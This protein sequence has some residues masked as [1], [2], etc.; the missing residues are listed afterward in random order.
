MI[1]P[2]LEPIAVPG[3]AP[4]A[5]EAARGRRRR[6]RRQ[7][8]VQARA[9]A[10]PVV[11][12][13]HTM[14]DRMPQVQHP[15]NGIGRRSLAPPFVQAPPFVAPPAPAAAPA[16]A[17]PMHV[18]LAA[19]A[20]PFVRAAPAAPAQ[21]AQPVA[22]PGNVAIAVPLLQALINPII[23]NRRQRKHRR[24]KLHG[25]F[26]WESSRAWR[27]YVTKKK[28]NKNKYHKLPKPESGR[29]FHYEN[30]EE[31][32]KWKETDDI[33]HKYKPRMV[34]K[35]SHVKHA[36]IHDNVDIHVGAHMLEAHVFNRATRKNIKYLVH[37]IHKQRGRLF[38]L[39]KDHKATPV[40]LMDVHTSHSPR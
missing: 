40:F 11:D 12:H 21:P 22:N 27:E 17:P 38:K 34:Q 14:D 33:D 4:L 29:G 2:Q 23:D 28:K 3:V 24:S 32:E 6:R 13:D 39:T 31:W 9:P 15:R 5:Y 35:H 8:I 19:P 20:P 30:A 18:Q 26:Y 37:V 10:G 25:A 16:P 36:R 1:I 7:R